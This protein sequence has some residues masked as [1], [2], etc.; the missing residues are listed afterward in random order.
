[1]NFKISVFSELLSVVEK[2]ILSA[3]SVDKS[4]WSK[5]V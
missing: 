2:T 4:W 5:I 3:I 1:L